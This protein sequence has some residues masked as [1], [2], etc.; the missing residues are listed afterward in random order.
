M[1][2]ARTT[3]AGLIGPQFGGI[4]KHRFGCE[5]LGAD[6]TA[7][8]CLSSGQAPWLSQGAVELSKNTTSS[9][10]SLTL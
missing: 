8:P 2:K 7:C 1:P 6:G 3:G 10:G 4:H 9:T 5:T